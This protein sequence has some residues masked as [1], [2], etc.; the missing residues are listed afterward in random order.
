M[1]LFEKRNIAVLAV[2][3]LL[4][5]A[6]AAPITAQAAQG[7][8]SPRFE[9][10]GGASDGM[11]DFATKLGLSENDLETCRAKG[12]SPRDLGQAAMLAK[13]SGKSLHEI[14]LAKNLDTSWK[15][16]ATSLGVTDEQ[17]KAARRDMMADRLEKKLSIAKATAL[18]L[19][20]K[21]Y[22]PRDI[23][24][25]HLIATKS[26]KNLD[27]VLGQK[28]INNTWSDVAQSFGVNFDE[29]RRSDS[30]KHRGAGGNEGRNYSPVHF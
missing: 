14:M 18:D 16:L 20:Q 4:L 25:A 26:G 13:L 1:K 3:G 28:K 2:G 11:R 5:G 12:V 10:R 9:H 17:I 19:L 30:D 24:A 22:N 21:G 6:L 15:D 27:E 8:Q 23:G 7:P 29:L